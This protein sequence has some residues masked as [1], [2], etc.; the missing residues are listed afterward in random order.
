[1]A[2]RAKASA[3]VAS[4]TSVG[5]RASMPESAAGKGDYVRQFDADEENYPYNDFDPYGDDSYWMNLKVPWDVEDVH[6][7]NDLSDW[8]QGDLLGTQLCMKDRPIQPTVGASSCSSSY[9]CPG[10]ADSGPGQ[11]Q[12]KAGH[13]R[14]TS[15]HFLSSPHIWPTLASI[16]E[17][18]PNPCLVGA[19]S[20]VSWP[21]ACQDP[22]R[23]GAMAVRRMTPTSARTKTRVWGA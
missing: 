9:T 13:S 21:A 19:C 3:E 8:D 4:A 15:P 5:I 14:S 2:G 18:E 7:R 11:I 10:L 22:V 20:V 1:M 23:I 16:G 6:K 12:P 17:D